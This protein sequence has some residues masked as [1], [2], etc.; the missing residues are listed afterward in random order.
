M[1]LRFEYVRDLETGEQPYICHE[2]NSVIYNYFIR[3]EKALD[4]HAIVPYGLY[5]NDIVFAN[6]ERHLTTKAVDRIGIKNFPGIGGI[7]FYRDA[8]S[9]DSRVIA[10]IHAEV[11]RHGAPILQSIAVEEGQLHIVIQPPSN[12]EYT[13]YRVIVRQEAFAF[14]YIVYKTDYLADLPTVIGTYQCYCIGYDENTGDISEDSNILSLTITEGNPD[15]KPYIPSIG[16]IER[17]VTAIEAEIQNYPD[18]EIHNDIAEI[19]GGDNIET[20]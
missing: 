19:L 14:E 13:C 5:D 9:D 2:P 15:W 1:S 17:R 20:N 4:T 7:G 12:I 11:N 6:E 3:N 18:E 10:P 16:D 8:Y